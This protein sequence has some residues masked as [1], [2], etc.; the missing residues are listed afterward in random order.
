MSNR[1]VK[2]RTFETIGSVRLKGALE[3]VAD[4]LD[5]AVYCIRKGEMAFSLEE[6]TSLA[7]YLRRINV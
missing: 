7:A 3:E 2:L 1:I 4:R 5:A 6:I